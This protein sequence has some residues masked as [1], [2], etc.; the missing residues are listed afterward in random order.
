MVLCFVQLLRMAPQLASSR[1]TTWLK[2]VISYAVHLLRTIL[3]LLVLTWMN[4]F[5]LHAPLSP[6][7]G[8]FV[9]LNICCTPN[10][11]FEEPFE[12][13]PALFFPHFTGR[14]F[15]VSFVCYSGATCEHYE[16]KQAVRKVILVWCLV[17]NPSWWETS[18]GSKLFLLSSRPFML[19][20]QGRNCLHLLQIILTL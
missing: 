9:I 20:V 13:R 11:C 19:P 1:R 8:Q 5:L 18:T 17:D 6:F 3:S 12:E 10:I 15:V 14:I 7:S 4:P 2:G 16:C